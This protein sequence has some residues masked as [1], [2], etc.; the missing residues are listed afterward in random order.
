MLTE[1]RDALEDV[2]EELTWDE[3]GC[4]AERVY[5]RGIELRDAAT[6]LIQQLKECKCSASLEDGIL[7]LDDGEQIQLVKTTN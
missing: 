7:T 6:K 3:S 5:D 2:L 1:L 4:R